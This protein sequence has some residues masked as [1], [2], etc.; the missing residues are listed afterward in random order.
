MLTSLMA[1]SRAAEHA[2]YIMLCITLHR[3]RAVATAGRAE[4][5]VT[6]KLRAAGDCC[7]LAGRH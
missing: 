4:P 5:T 1:W 7:K 2:Q 3:S 6:R